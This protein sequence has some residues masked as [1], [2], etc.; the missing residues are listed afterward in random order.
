MFSNPLETAMPQRTVESMSVADRT[1]AMPHG[2][3]REIATDL[4]VPESTVSAVIRGTWRPVKA[5]GRETARRIQEAAA[6]KLGKSVEFVFGKEAVKEAVPHTATS[7]SRKRATA[8]VGGGS[9]AR[10]G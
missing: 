5:Q 3:Q 9:R 7:A 2:A 8:D 4:R 6:K 1:F 10:A